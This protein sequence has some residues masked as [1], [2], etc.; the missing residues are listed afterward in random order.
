MFYWKI[1]TQTSQT[2]YFI[3]SSVQGHIR[4]YNSTSRHLIRSRYFTSICYGNI[5]YKA[6]KCR[7]SPQG[8]TKPLNILIKKGYSYDTVVRSLKIAYYGFNIDSAFMAFASEINTL[9]LNPVVSLMTWQQCRNN[10]PS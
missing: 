6:H 3:L 2:I 9:I 8:I 5:L 4:K 1:I 7:Q 10:I